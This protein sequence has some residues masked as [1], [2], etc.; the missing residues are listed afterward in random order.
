[1]SKMC[2][3][4]IT[5]RNNN[6]LQVKKMNKKFL[7]KK[8]KKWKRSLLTYLEKRNCRKLSE[9]FKFCTTIPI[10]DFIKMDNRKKLLFLVNFWSIY[11]K[12]RFISKRRRLL[13]FMIFIKWHLIQSNF[14]GQ[15][16]FQ[17]SNT[18]LL[19]TIPQ[20]KAPLRDDRI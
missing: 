13:K 20:K 7:L 3:N 9:R 10:N 4:H 19:A 17:L 11:R 12:K 18:L 15:I 2:S 1:M 14:I 8:W 6:T 5:K 16:S